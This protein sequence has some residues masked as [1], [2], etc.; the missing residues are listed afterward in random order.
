[1]TAKHEKHESA[2]NMMQTAKVRKSH[3]VNPNLNKPRKRVD[4]TKDDVI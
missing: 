3:E 1:M 2:D 4:I